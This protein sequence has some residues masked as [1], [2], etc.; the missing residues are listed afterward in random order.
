MSTTIS[1]G[2]VKQRLQLA[3]ENGRRQ[4]EALAEAL[5]ECLAELA[6]AEEM[7][8]Q[9]V[10]KIGRD[11]LQHWSESADCQTPT[12]E[13]EHCQEAMR[14][15]GYVPGSLVTTLGN[16]TLRRV[17]HRC[18]HCGAECYPQDKRLRFRGHAV[19][20]PLAKV[21]SRLGA[22][23]PFAQACQ[24]LLA[25]YG[26]QLSKQTIQRVCEHAGAA[27]VDEEDR[28]RM[29]LMSLAV[30]P[31]AAALPD[32]TISPEKAYVFGDGAMI[33]MA[34]DWHEIRV[35]SVA[36]TDAQ[37]RP[38]MVDHRAR[39]LSC[40][41][42]GW[43]LLLLARSAG[44]HRAKL[45]A[46]IADGARWL[47]EAAATHFPD[48]VQILDWYHLSEH[49][50]QAAAKLYGEGSQAAQQFS[51]ARLEELWAG[52]VKDTLAALKELRKAFRAAS[53]RETL[54]QLSGYLENNRQRID[55]PRYRE[56]GLRIGSGQVES[57]CKTLVGM[58]CKQAG[59]RNW[60]KRGAEGVLYLR[61]ALQTGRYDELWTPPSQSAA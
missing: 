19:S 49:V 36:A 37:D 61:A 11:L 43:Q 46:F 30:A 48:A 4:L 18:E 17:R 10:L 1:S 52:R 58:R 60:T 38:L 31:R 14:H 41:D 39:F 53:K 27:L 7:I 12:P 3:V 33:H 20:W 5:P 47:W 13:C 25:D 16:L 8:R 40:T 6:C 54:R 51:Q 24:N 28:H 9:E 42:F 34:G 26:V 59:M 50:H 57:A 32:S 55:Y 21:V 44:Y 22:Q 15:K 35:A 56:L 45:R 2:L 29:E 23:L